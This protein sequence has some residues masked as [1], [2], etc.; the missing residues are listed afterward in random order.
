MASKSTRTVRA[1]RPR[2]PGTPR[3]RK[4]RGES[5]GARNRISEDA[6]RAVKRKSIGHDEHLIGYGRVSTSG[7]DL[8]LQLDALR[9]AGCERIYR[10]VGSGSIRRRPEL[11]ACLDYLRQ[12][13]TLVVWRL[14]RLGRSLRHLI[15][16]VAGLQ[17]RHIAFRS[18]KENIDT[19]TATGRLFFHLVGALAEFERELI[20][21]RSAAGREAARAR[22]RHGGR[23]KLLT[24]DK[25]AAAIAMRAQGQ[26]TMSQIAD[27]LKVGRST[28]Y[29]HLNLRQ[30]EPETA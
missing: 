18:L 7:Q 15:D 2:S 25:L 23:P 29:Q 4:E 11:D 19:S 10:D 14:D 21:E 5:H 27:V 3:S 28:L 8:A 20:R 13:D 24:P 6:A 9:S 22:G 1:D 17:E 26:L 30:D 16:L 12:G